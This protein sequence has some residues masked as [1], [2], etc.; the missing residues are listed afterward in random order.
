[1]EEMVLNLLK[2]LNFKLIRFYKQ[3]R[4]IVIEYSD[5]NG[6]LYTSTYNTIKVNKSSWIF[7]KHNKYTIQN[8]RRYIEINNLKYIILDKKFKGTNHKAKYIDADG[9]YYGITISQLTSGH[10]SQTFCA[11]NP[12]TIKNIKNWCRINNKR[13]KLIS[14][15]FIKSSLKMKWKCLD[16]DEYFDMKWNHIHG[17]I[18]CPYCAHIKLSTKHSLMYM[19]PDI[20]EEWDA[21]KNKMSADMVFNQTPKKYWWK[22]SFCNNEFHT[23][24]NARSTVGCPSC[25]SWSLGEDRIRNF[26]DEC[27][28]KYQEQKAFDNLKNKKPLRCDF[29]LE[30]YNLVIE[31]QGV[32]H[33][34]AIS[35]FGGEKSLL[36]QQNCDNIKRDYFKEMNISLLEI[37]YYDFE[38]IEEM[39]KYTLFL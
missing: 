1:M 10:N 25:S 34:K 9:Y 35:F 37:P 19:R 36:S 6:Y 39:L 30:D 24:P 2:P 26:L 4:E 5:M 38:N 33:Y 15:K 21:L 13:Y 27:G 7:S 18:G 20:A 28:I 22:C 32:Q 29:Y 23:S 3:K 12:Y 8:I 11:S 16:C 31:Y 17:D 14:K